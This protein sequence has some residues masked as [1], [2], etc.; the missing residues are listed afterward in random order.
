MPDMTGHET[1]EAII[2]GY[3]VYEEALK[4]RPGA[5]F[6]LP[7]KLPPP[8]A[9]ARLRADVEL[10]EAVEGMPKRS[11]LKAMGDGT[12]IWEGGIR[13]PDGTRKLAHAS[14]PTPLAA[15]RN[16]GLAPKEESSG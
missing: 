14:G 12:Y 6:N 3:A 2:V 4:A 8:V 5:L 1:L 7:A 11:A 13:Q 10:A 16:A 15:L 9:L